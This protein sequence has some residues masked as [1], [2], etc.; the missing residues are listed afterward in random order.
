MQGHSGPGSRGI[1][2]TKP[3]GQPGNGPEVFTRA[4]HLRLLGGDNVHRGMVLGALL[5]LISDNVATRWFDE[6]VN[7]EAIYREADA[8]SGCNG[9]K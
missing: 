2:E 5:E 1:G 4:L 8:L 3:A 6:L 7:S 9:S